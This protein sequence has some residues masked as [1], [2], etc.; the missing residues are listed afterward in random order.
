MLLKSKDALKVIEAKHSRD[1]LAQDEALWEITVNS[2]VGVIWHWKSRP[3][4]KIPNVFWHF[5]LQ[6]FSILFGRAVSCQAVYILKLRCDDISKLV[7]V[8]LTTSRTCM[9]FRTRMF[10]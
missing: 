7:L 10:R 6:I 1:V 5:G 8:L 9:Y 3:F 4:P 2:I